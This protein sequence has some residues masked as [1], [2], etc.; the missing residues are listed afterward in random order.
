MDRLVEFTSNNVWLVTALVAAGL[1]ALFNELRIKSQ[2]LTAVSPAMAVQLINK[3]AQV[4]DVRTGEQFTSGH[5]VDA[6]NIPEKELLYGTDN[7]LKKK[8]VVLVCDSG[9]SSGRCAT[10]LRK[11]GR[12]QVFSLKGGLAAWRQ[13]NLPVVGGG[14]KS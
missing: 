5:I 11:T 8:T 12:D 2:G 7:Q 4:I 10:G 6:R 9:A 3:G 14:G 1:A 13:E